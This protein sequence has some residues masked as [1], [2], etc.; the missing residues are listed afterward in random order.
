MCLSLWD[1]WNADIPR[2]LTLVIKVQT[3]ETEKQNYAECVNSERHASYHHLLGHPVLTQH[4]NNT[5]PLHP[6]LAQ[7]G[8]STLPYH[9]GLHN[10]A[11]P[12]K[13]TTPPCSGTTW[14]KH[15]STPPHFT[16]HDNTAPIHWTLKSKNQP[17]HPVSCSM[18]ITQTTQCCDPKWLQDINSPPSSHHLMTLYS[19]ITLPLHL[20]LNKKVRP[21]HPQYTHTHLIQQWQQQTPP[22]NTW[23][24]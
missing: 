2:R 13:I 19:K 8:N 10:T 9:N 11:T 4:G 17:I 23:Q 12:P 7:H 3:L 22:P 5:L 14:Q 1:F 18:A 16:W 20:C 21:P 6:V 24:Q 15:I